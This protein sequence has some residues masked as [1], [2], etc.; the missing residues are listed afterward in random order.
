MSPGNTKDAD[1]KESVVSTCVKGT[2]GVVVLST[3]PI[4]VNVTL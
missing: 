1:K 3:V 4:T 2:D